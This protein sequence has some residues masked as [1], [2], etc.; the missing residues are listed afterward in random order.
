LHRLGDQTAGLT[1]SR[2]MQEIPTGLP[3]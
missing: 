3:V 1:N 2:G